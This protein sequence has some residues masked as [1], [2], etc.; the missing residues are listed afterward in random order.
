MCLGGFGRPNGRHFVFEARRTACE[1][2]PVS[3][4]SRD[5]VT[6]AVSSAERSR[7]TLIRGVLLFRW[8]WLLWLV[9]MAATSSDELQNRLLAFAAV[10]GALLWTVWLSFRRRRFGDLVL[11]IDLAFCVFLIVVSALVVDP[12]AVVSGRPFFATGY[13]LSAPLLWGAARGPL[14]GLFAGAVLGAAIVLSRPLNGI[15]LGELADTPGGIQNLAGAVINYLV[16][17]VAVG[18]VSRV[19][20]RSD[21]AVEQAT[22]ELVRERERAA[23]LSERET[24]G[25]HIHDSVL[26]ALAFVHKRGREIAASRN[27]SRDEVAELATIAGRQEQEL[28]SLIV[29]GPEEP[30]GNRTSL[31]DALEEAAR[32]VGDLETSVSTIGPLWIDARCASELAAATRQALENVAKHSGATTA[33]VFAEQEDGSLMITVRDRGKGFAY[34]EDRLRAAHKVGILQSMKGRLEDLG[35]SMSIDTAPG[36]GTEIEFRAPVVDE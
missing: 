33:S 2:V 3:D 34:D 36:K 6:G 30:R 29:R 9:V 4:V 12:G 8:V 11:G 31:R 5:E 21:E 25:R 27:L 26:Q 19:L 10:G 7:R 14:P 24:L 16:A 1:S 22:S 18:L 32:S 17:G 23:R 28:R 20:Q 35:G 15:A 13:P